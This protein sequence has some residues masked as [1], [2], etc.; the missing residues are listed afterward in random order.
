M[1]GFSL[2][3]DGYLLTLGERMVRGEVPYRDFSYIR[4]PL[5]VMIQATLLAAV[6][7]YAV[8][9]SRWHFALQV[10]AILAVIQALLARVDQAP[11][12]P[13]LRYV[14]D[15]R[16]L[17]DPRLAPIIAYLR[18][19]FHQGQPFGERRLLRP[20]PDGAGDPGR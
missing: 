8:A 11:G 10:A 1:Q 4:P 3:E 12:R 16:R 6:P 18:T 15:P 14:Q 17:G 7:G 2:R 20:R 9:A 13:A 5:P 19:R